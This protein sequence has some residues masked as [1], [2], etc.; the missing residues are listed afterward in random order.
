MNSTT[1]EPNGNRN[2]H[3]SLAARITHPG[4]KR[5]RAAKQH[6]LIRAATELFASRGYEATT[7]REIAALAGCAEGLIHRY[8]ESKAGLLLALI[9]GKVSQEVV[10]LNEKL[11]LVPNV[12]EELV[13]LVNWE[14]DRMWGDR[15]FLRVIVPRALVDPGLGQVITRIGPLQHAKAIA[16]RLRKF[17]ECR[18]LPDQEIDALAH[19]VSVTGFMFGFMRPVVL[20]QDRKCARRTATTIARILA[21][22]F[23][24]IP[25]SANGHIS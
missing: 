16:E 18:A 19:F 11:R 23:Q 22:S 25:L 21:R 15:E 17:K 12:G 1:I 9:R 8:F 10:D 14:I 13:Q 20:R 5:D 6:A 24:P 2:G 7:T 3:K 4:K